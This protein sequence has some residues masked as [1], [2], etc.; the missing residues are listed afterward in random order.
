MVSCFIGGGGGGYVTLLE[1]KIASSF[2]IA[3]AVKCP[4]PYEVS[5]VNCKSWIL[6]SSLGVPFIQAPENCYSFRIKWPFDC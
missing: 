1:T 3:C 4:E 2:C 5:F 6:G